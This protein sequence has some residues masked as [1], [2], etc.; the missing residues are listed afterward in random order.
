MRTEP[1][2]LVQQLWRMRGPTRIVRADVFT[3]VAGWE[4]VVSFEGREDDV[5]RTQVEKVDVA[6][7]EQRANQLRDVLRE[8]GWLD[9][10]ISDAPQ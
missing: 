9:A 3:H 4:L 5:L 7:L 2:R 6:V 8:K 1:R 10:P